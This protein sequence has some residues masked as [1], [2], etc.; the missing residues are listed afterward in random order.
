MAAEATEGAFG[1]LRTVTSC[2]EQAG[3]RYMVVGGLATF[4]WGTPRTTRDFDLAVLAEEDPSQVGSRLRKALVATK[5]E[6]QGPFSTEFGMRFVLPFASVPF[7]VFVA[8]REDAAAFARRREVR[9]SGVSVWV[10]APED[11]IAGKLRNA[12]R[13]PDEERSDLADAAGVAFK[14]WTQLDRAYLRT[15]CTELGLAREA[16]ALLGDVATA[17]AKQG[18]PS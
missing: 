10:I 7:D 8:A 9:L 15:R 17:R 16:D 6:P 1:A 5:V 13:F 4:A 3:Y 2:L 18:L 14:Q 12:V 11:F